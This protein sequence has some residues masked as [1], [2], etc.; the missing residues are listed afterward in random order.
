MT[1]SVRVA[2]DARL[3]T[4]ASG[5]VE[6]V[7]VGLADG[8]SAIEHPDVDISFVAYTGHTEWL[9]RLIGES[10]QLIEV[11]PPHKPSPQL[12]RSLGPLAEPARRLRN[13]IKG[14][15]TRLP[16]D[17]QLDALKPD[18]VHLPHQEV[19]LVAAPFIYHPHDLQHLHM[20]EFFSKETLTR[21]ETFYGPLCR[22]AARVA[23]GTSWVKD[24]VVAKL[25]IEP[26]KVVVIP[27]APVATVTASTQ[28]PAGLPASYLLYPAAA[29]PHKNHMRLLQAFRILVDAHPDAHLVLTGARTGVDLTA[30]VRDLGLSDHV[31]VL[32]FLPE[33]DLAAVYQHARGVVV[34]T[35]FESASFPVWE[36]FERG[37]PVA[38]SS[39]TA[40][41]RQVGDAAIVFD[42]YD[43]EEIADAMSQLWTDPQLR[44]ALITQ[45][46]LRVSE[47]SWLDTA[48]RFLALYR[49]VAG[50]ATA[51]D[52][53]LLA[54]EP[55]I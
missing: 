7:L 42:P 41:P 3:F 21:R 36:A 23:V 54:Q 14:V 51:A 16:H 38:C 22:A 5:G 2:V 18:V 34:P 43:V 33:R 53:S 52:V 26:A 15:H 28:S 49:E 24:D 48:R 9:A 55:K 39:V 37:V 10:I 29:W 8:L 1:N 11:Q 46:K 30:N 35:L 27:L 12:R 19:G 47:F 32:G 45:G 44:A 13:S 20:P 6:T 4:G 31:H 50:V 25:G 40:L 17:H